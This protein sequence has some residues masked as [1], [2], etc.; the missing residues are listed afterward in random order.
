MV[1]DLFINAVIMI[2][3]ITLGNQVI[4]RKF[5]LN[6]ASPVN[7]QVASGVLN[8]V[9]GC[10]LM[11]YSV[12]VIPGVIIDFRNYAILLSSALGGPVSSIIASLMLGA[13]RIL[14]Y[15]LHRSSITSAIIILLIGTGCS[16]ISV[17][18]FSFLRKWI[19]TNIFAAVAGSIMFVFL[20]SDRQILYRVLI[21]YWVGNAVVTVVLYYYLSYIITTNELFQKYKEEAAVDYLT[22]L[23]NVRQFDRIYNMV[24][25]K[26]VTKG[27][28]LS[29]LFIDIDFFKKVNDT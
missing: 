23:N 12:N 5:K 29:L 20:I 21:F 3:F 11:L 1:H 2:T 25:E 16:F 8:G 17:R 9:V 19:Y 24:S 22:G 6:T 13:F 26:A 14:Y 7:L 4:Y 18:N 28:N 10:V 27:E 15:G